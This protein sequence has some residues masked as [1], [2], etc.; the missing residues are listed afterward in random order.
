MSGSSSSSSITHCVTGN[1]FLS[2][3]LPSQ[4]NPRVGKHLAGQWD[5]VKEQ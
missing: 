2:A 5:A 1:A 4:W 3:E